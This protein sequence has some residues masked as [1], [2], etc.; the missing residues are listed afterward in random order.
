M[1]DKIVFN[2]KIGDKEEELAVRRPTVAEQDEAQKEY[3]KC[4]TKAM[5][6]EAVPRSVLNEHMEKAG[7]WNKDK[8]VKLRELASEIA[9]IEKIFHDGG[10]KKS[11]AFTFED[12]KPAGLIMD[13]RRLRREANQLRSILSEN[14]DVTIEGQADNRKFNYLLSQC[15]VYNKSG[16][17]YWKN[18][19]DYLNKLSED[20]TIQAL[21]KFTLLIYQL[22]SDFESKLP[23]NKLLKLFSEWEKKKNADFQGYCDEK[24]RILLDGKLIDDE[25]RLINEHGQL[26]NSNGKVIDING[27]LLDDKGEF[28]GESKPFL[29]DDEKPIQETEL[30]STE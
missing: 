10:I 29:D 24:F 16:Q 30:I 4:F 21:R 19:Q 25:G 18:Y 8:E 13:I 11:T 14:I 28:T 23:E 22:D 20:V 27:N 15:L 2:V 5:R 6:D 7:V 17:K 12:G 1:I 3:I 9:R 26:V